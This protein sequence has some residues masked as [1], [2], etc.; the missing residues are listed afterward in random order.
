MTQAGDHTED[1]I[2][3]VGEYALHLLDAQS[4]LAFEKRLLNDATLRRLLRD[5]DEGLISLAD[6]ISP[7]APPAH[8]KGAIEARLFGAPAKP[9]FSW[10]R[11]FGSR[12]IALGLVALLAV[13]TYFGTALLK[14][15]QG[16]TFVAEIA[17]EDRAL[18]VEVRFDPG[19]GEIGINRIAGAAAAGRALELWLIADGASAPVSLGVLPASGQAVLPVPVALRNAMIGATLAISDEPPGGSPTGAPTGAV[20]AVGKIISS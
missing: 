3:L 18:V 13:S 6:D 10:G 8:L 12:G 5:W 19:A 15:P 7:V 17:A 20:L 2:A 11:L 4:R 1:D 9:G 14:S 16:P